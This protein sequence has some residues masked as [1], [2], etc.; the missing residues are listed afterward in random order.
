MI[1]I[2]RRGISFLD[3]TEPPPAGESWRDYVRRLQ[4]ERQIEFA[5]TSR[6]H[7]EYQSRFVAFRFSY[8][9]AR[10]FVKDPSFQRDIAALSLSPDDWEGWFPKRLFGSPC[11]RESAPATIFK[12]APN[13]V[14]ASH[15]Q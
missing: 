1:D 12:T 2:S 10:E 7:D 14:N 13:E 3:I 4:L 5:Q 11:F 6:S 9:S 15:D 8:E